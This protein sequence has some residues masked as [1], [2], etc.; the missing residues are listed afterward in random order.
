VKSCVEAEPCNQHFA[1]LQ[2]GPIKEYLLEDAYQKRQRHKD[3]KEG[4]LNADQ[5]EELDDVA[6]N[7]ASSSRAKCSHQEDAEYDELDGE[8]ISAFN[9]KDEREGGFDEETGEFTRGRGEED[10]L[11]P[12]LASLQHEVVRLEALA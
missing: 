11:D 1:K 10:D 12:W 8:Q 4:V 6:G 7:G 2:E 5:F 9:M 3:S